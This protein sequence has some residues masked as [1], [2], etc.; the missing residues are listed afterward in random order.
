MQIAPYTAVAACLVTACVVLVGPISGSSL[1]PARSLGPAVMSATYRSLWV[2]L[3]APP[4]GALV[5]AALYRGRQARTTLCAKL[6]HDNTY[7]CPFVAC[8]YQAS[9]VPERS[10]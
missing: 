8:A 9:R 10:T 7:P 2:Y 4:L 6:Y 1:N 3:V 5:A